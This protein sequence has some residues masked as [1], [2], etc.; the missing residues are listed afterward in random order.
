MGDT[1]EAQRKWLQG[2]GIDTT[3]GGSAALGL[4]PRLTPADLQ[5]VLAD[6]D[7]KARKE[8][9]DKLAAVDKALADARVY[10]EQIPRDQLVRSSYAELMKAVRSRFPELAG[11]PQWVKH[12]GQSVPDLKGKLPS[13]RAVMDLLENLARSSGAE[14]SWSLSTGRDATTVNTD[15]LLAAYMSD[16][17]AGVSVSIK[18]GVVQLSLEGAAVSVHVPGGEVDATADKGGAAVALKSGDV[19]IQVTNEGWKEFDPELRGQW[20][21]IKDATATVL[22]LKADRDKAKLELEQKKKD[23]AQTSADLTA[24]FDKREAAFNLA[25]TKLQEQIK[26]HAKV[27]EDTV[28]ASIAYLKKDKNNKE[29]VK[30]GVEAEADLKEMQAKLKAYFANPTIEAA[31]EVTASADKV[32]AKLELT[33]VK[34]G[35]VVTARFEKAL[36]ETKAAIE[37]MLREGK[38]KVAAELKKKADELSAQIKVVHQTKDLKLAAQLETTLKEVRGSIELEYS[39]GSVAAKGSANVSS[40]GEAGG[41][42]QIDIALEKGRTFADSNGKLSFAAGVSTKGYTFEVTFSIGEPVDTASLQDLFSNADKQIKELYKLAGDKGVRSIQDAEELNRKLQE[43]MAPVKA[44]ADK[45]KTLK[46]KSEISASF[47]F[48]VQGDWPSG[49]K[50]PPPTVS[51]GV[52]IHF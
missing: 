16:L 14:M 8:A 33:A 24:D 18:G 1:T 17:P 40:G 22:K 6:S 28:T 30:A 25:W 39:K 29:S 19:S 36:D 50:A 41:K 51:V 44:A 31:L 35:V 21:Q 12:T 26:A 47:G 9:Q 49:G 4:P 32:S 27:S 42:V 13:P 45:A 2:L 11:L 20:S 23:G 38:T 46:N 10:L 3:V 37:V 7:A 15:R 34:S 48:S 5:R 52:T 43:V